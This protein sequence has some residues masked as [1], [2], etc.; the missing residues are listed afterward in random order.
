M[1]NP[2]RDS[3]DRRLP[4]VPEPCV[5][6][7]FGAMA[8]PTLEISSGDVIFKQVVVKGFWA[9]KIFPAMSKEKRATL[10]GELVAGITSGSLTLPVE[11]VFTLE[12]IADAARASAQPG[13]RGKILLRP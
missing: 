8:S 13:R 7:V 4:R 1:T 10:M 9:S 3:R 12:D 6:V 11:E 2:L 5:L